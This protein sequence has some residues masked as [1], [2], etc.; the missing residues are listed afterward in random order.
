MP[1]HATGWEAPAE[2]VDRFSAATKSPNC[3][4]LGD[5]HPFGT[6]Q[7]H[8][9]AV[10]SRIAAAAQGSAQVPVFS[11]LTGIASKVDKSI[12]I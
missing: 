2:L 12:A 5:L 9:L 4:R 3:L 8:E 7:S 11:I 6:Q 10:D 1:D